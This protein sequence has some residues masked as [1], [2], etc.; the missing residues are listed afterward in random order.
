MTIIMYIVHAKIWY[1]VRLGKYGMYLQPICFFSN[2]I[3]RFMIS[4]PPPKKK[5]LVLWSHFF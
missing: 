3:L 4:P 5:C 1:M 2:N